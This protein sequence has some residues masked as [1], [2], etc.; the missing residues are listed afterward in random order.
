M[1][2]STV[3]KN[4]IL[5]NI[6]ID[7]V[8]YINLYIYSYTYLVLKYMSGLGWLNELGSWII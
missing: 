2:K 4:C 6:L 1:K 3:I 8:Y 7:L 5:S